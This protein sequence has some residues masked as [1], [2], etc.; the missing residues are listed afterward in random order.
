[1]ASVEGFPFLRFPLRGENTRF[2]QLCIFTCI[3]AVP[4]DCFWPYGLNLSLLWGPLDHFLITF[5]SLGAHF[6]RI[7]RCF[8]PSTLKNTFV[9]AT[10]APRGI[11][12]LVFYGVLCSQDLFLPLN[13]HTFCLGPS[14]THMYLLVV[15]IF[16]LKARMC[17]LVFHKKTRF[18][19][20]LEHYWATLGVIYRISW[21][22]RMFFVSLP[23]KNRKFEGL[24]PG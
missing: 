17:L 14:K 11:K 20:A 3:F 21:R 8:L 22:F 23:P 19:R 5:S 24:W 12:M 4:R 10:F 9:F 1:M 15:A 6:A 7:L 2:Q 16:C 18:A 13:M